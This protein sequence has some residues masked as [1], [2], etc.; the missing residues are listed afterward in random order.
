M[1]PTEKSSENADMKNSSWDSVE[2]ILKTQESPNQD[3]L[4]KQRR[5]LLKL[6][7]E[8]KNEQPKD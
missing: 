3:L 5:L 4:A 6:S 2:S 7:N 8:R 1:K